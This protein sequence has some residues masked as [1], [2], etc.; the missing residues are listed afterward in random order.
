MMTVMASIICWNMI[1]WHILEILGWFLQSLGVAVILRLLVYREI[2]SPQIW[3]KEHS[4]DIPV[5]VFLSHWVRG[6]DMVCRILQSA[7]TSLVPLSISLSFPDQWDPKPQRHRDYL[8]FLTIGQFVNDRCPGWV[9]VTE[10]GFLNHISRMR[11]ENFIDCL[12]DSKG[13][14]SNPET[15]GGTSHGTSPQRFCARAIYL[16]GIPFYKCPWVISYTSFGESLWRQMITEEL[17][18]C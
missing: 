5:F 16:A 7:V 2:K 18:V 12:E 14:L 9:A 6:K 4:D 8:V 15:L 10:Q 1:E 13:F 3:S 11:L 17:Q